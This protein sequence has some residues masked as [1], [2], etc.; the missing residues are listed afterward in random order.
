M[1]AMIIKASLW[2]NL[3]FLVFYHA[4]YKT[5]TVKRKGYTIKPKFYINFRLMSQ[6]MMKWKHEKNRMIKDKIFIKHPSTMEDL[7]VTDLI[8]WNSLNEFGK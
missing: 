2:L 8:T 3:T 1:A 6:I 7:W 5:M 4:F